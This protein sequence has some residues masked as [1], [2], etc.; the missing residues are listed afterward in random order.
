M[1]NVLA[2]NP[3]TIVVLVSSFPIGIGWLNDNVP[4]ILHVT[5]SSQELGN[6]VAD[7]L[8]G[9][10][11]PGGHTTTTWYQSEND[12]PTALTDYDIKQGTTYWYFTGTNLVVSAPS[13]S[14]S[15]SA[16]SC[17]AVQV[18]LD[19]ANT[20]AVSGDEVVQ[21][22]VAY[23]NSAVA[24]RPLKQLRG[25]QRITI[26]AGTTTHVT[27]TVAARDLAYYDAA[28]AA[29]IVEG[30]V[31]VELQV[32]SSSADIRLRGTLNVVP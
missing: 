6:A 4:A 19:V 10:Y 14:P 24:Q 21:L 28:S 18:S 32:G 23:P 31:A 9:D 8:F 29:F 30:G 16:D 25:F 13:V 20:S 1:Q 2:A 22:Y 26:D 27:F 15:A 7:A 12:I 3:R 5:N 17:A 11:N